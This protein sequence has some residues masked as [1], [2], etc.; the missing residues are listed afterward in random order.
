MNTPTLLI[1]DG[2]PHAESLGS[3]LC[4]AYSEGAKRGGV[5][6]E[7]LNL[8]EL[9]FDPVLHGGYSKKTHQPLEPDLVRAQ[10]SIESAAHVTWVFPMWWA[11]VPALVK[12]FVDRVFLPGWAFEYER[13]K[14]MPKRLLSGRSARVV[15]TMDSPWWW[16]TLA[17][18]SAIHGAFSNATLS[19]VGFSPVKTRT[20][21][22]VRSMSD[23]DRAGLIATLRGD[24]ASDAAATR[25][26]F[27]S[28]PQLEARAR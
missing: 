25:K 15:A 7:R 6:L 16:Y 4:D 10:Q 14:A 13:G 18:K 27:M 12:G 21:H 28:A 9:S 8:R 5:A 26:R 24:G 22:S 2:H 17:Y 11:S 23:A 1:I 19:F 3:A 20:V